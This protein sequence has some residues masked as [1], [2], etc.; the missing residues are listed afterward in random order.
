MY[1]TIFMKIHILRKFKKMYY[2]LNKKINYIIYRE[3]Y[4][5]I[6]FVYILHIFYYLVQLIYI[7]QNLFLNYI[8]FE[9]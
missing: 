3:Q 8:K 5:I 4:N 7:S 2:K 1:D 6:R 9:H